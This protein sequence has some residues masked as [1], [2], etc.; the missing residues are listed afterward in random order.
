[1]EVCRKALV[2]V[3]PDLQVYLVDFS[4]RGLSTGRGYDAEFIVSGPDWGKL[5]AYSA[6]I[7]KHMIASPLL[8][9]VYDNYLFGLPDIQIVPDRKRAAL[10]GVSVEDL[11][12]V[13]G[14]LVGG[15]TFTTVY[16]HESGHDNDIFIRLLQ[17]QRLKP[18]DL[19]NIYIRNNRGELLPVSDV[20]T[21]KQVSALQQITRDNR[22]RAVSF[23]G[24]RSA[25]GPPAT[26]LDRGHA[27]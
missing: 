23:T 26:G 19:Q 11:G 2:K 5:G 6:E 21:I 8:A 18:E 17:N 25:Q 13:L 16:Y 27:I 3:S 9:D 15:Y 10:E 22:Q 20:T 14:V 12:T 1:M 4:K 7:K 24:Q